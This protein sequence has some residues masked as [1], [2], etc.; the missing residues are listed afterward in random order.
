MDRRARFFLGAGAV[1]ALLA[2]PLD[3]LVWVPVALAGA[4]FL[5]AALSW[6][7]WHSRRRD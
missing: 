5:F 1:C 3:E 6:L 2:L 7:D 4:Y